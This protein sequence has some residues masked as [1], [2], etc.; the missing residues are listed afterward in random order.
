MS[1]VDVG[2]ENSSSID[3]YHEDHGSGPVV[4][5]ISGW[6]FDGRSWEPRSTH[7][8]LPAAAW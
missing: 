6:P 8:W 5:L 4:V 3:I 1:T 2:Q 7:C